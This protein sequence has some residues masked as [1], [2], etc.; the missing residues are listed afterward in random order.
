MEKNNGELKLIKITKV[1]GNVKQSSF[2]V[3][4]GKN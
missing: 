1:S 2:D 4:P 3:K